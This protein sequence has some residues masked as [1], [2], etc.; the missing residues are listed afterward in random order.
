MKL[1]QK[2]TVGVLTVLMLALAVSAMGVI[3]LKMRP[4][5]T[6]RLAAPD[7]K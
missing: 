4:I 2:F 3:L 5:T 7:L 6:E 1:R